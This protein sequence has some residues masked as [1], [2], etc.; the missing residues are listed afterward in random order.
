MKNLALLAFLPMVVLSA[1]SY[2]NC[3][4]VAGVA[5]GCEHHDV[6]H[7]RVH[8]E[9]YWHNDEYHHGDSRQYSHGYYRN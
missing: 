7:R 9:R 4:R 1:P 3:V 5:V 6:E 8:E 2:A